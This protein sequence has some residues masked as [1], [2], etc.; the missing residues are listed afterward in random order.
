MTK[1]IAPLDCPLCNLLFVDKSDVI[2]WHQHGC[3]STCR[4]FFMYPN[5]SKWVKGWRPNKEEVDEL[6]K[7]INQDAAYLGSSPLKGV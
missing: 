1:Q 5:R 7:R 6:L 3:C 2:A 4:D